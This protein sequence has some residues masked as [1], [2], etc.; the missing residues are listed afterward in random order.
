M[1]EWGRARKAQ[2]VLLCVLLTCLSLCPAAA[3]GE[4][5]D[6]PQ[7]SPQI[8]RFRSIL[9]SLIWK[10]NTLPRTRR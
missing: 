2:A 5:I 1:S 4:A 10:G 7:A 6:A 9:C 3:L 8:P